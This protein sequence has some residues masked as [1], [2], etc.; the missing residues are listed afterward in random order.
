MDHY[1]T[2]FSGLKRAL[3]YNEDQTIAST[4]N[5]A[6]LLILSGQYGM[7][8]MW[9]ELEFDLCW[10]AR[11][12][13]ATVGPSERSLVWPEHWFAE[14]YTFRSNSAMG[15]NTNCFTASF[16]SLS[17]EAVDLATRQSVSYEYAKGYQLALLTVQNRGCVYCR[18][19]MGA[20]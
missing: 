1:R 18:D 3:L 6:V 7:I 13:A 9:M 15:T 20:M 14:I 4:I 19:T 11:T 5:I 12:W 10:S 8:Y 16:K 2:W 17:P